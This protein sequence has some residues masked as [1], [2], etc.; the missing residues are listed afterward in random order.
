VVE[1]SAGCGASTGLAVGMGGLASIGCEE[2]PERH[3]DLHT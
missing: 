2:P 3:C 1:L